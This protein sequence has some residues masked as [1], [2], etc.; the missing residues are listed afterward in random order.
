MA[1]MK[2]GCHVSIRS[3]YLAAAK[4]ALALG[5]RSFQYFPKNPRSL[6][7]KRFDHRDAAMCRAYCEEHQLLS[8]VH[9]PYPTNLS[10]DAPELYTATIHSLL[11]DLEIADACGSA[12]IVVHFGQYKGASTDPLYGYQRMISML[13]EIL[14]RWEG[15]ALILLE[16]N[17]GQGGR[18]G[19]TLEELSEVRSLLA[20]P[21]KIGFCLDTCHAFASGMWTGK[22]WPQVAEKARGMGYLPHLRAVHL[23]DS[24][25]PSA[26]R[27]DRHA[28]IGHGEIGVEALVELLQTPEVSE[29]PVILE[30]PTPAS[31]SHRE[32][33]A[34]VN[35]FF[36]R[37]YP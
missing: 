2:F 10:V 33:I 36:D 25:Y 24:R 8:I 28:N 16:N 7:V 27:R 29:L 4:T 32:E 19:T 22:N 11:N 37:W 3:G 13:N 21:E 6:S 23:N 26:S 17:A 18:M 31:G 9:T 20:H 30:T 15:Q 14:G 5:A 12:G 1:Y 34:L 35:S